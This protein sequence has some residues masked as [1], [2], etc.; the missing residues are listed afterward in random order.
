MTTVRT[1]VAPLRSARSRLGW[2]SALKRNVGSSVKPTHIRSAALAPVP[3]ATARTAASASARS[4]LIGGSLRAD[5][6]RRAVTREHVGN[7]ALEVLEDREQCPVG[8]H[9]PVERMGCAEPGLAT[10]AD[11]EAT[12]LEV[13]RIRA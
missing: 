9:R 12:R 5:D 1:M 2:R 4:G 3:R 10:A 7:V 13:R 11:A 6:G 8:D